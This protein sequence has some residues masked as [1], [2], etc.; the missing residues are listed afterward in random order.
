[1]P[2]AYMLG[3]SAAVVGCLW[4]V[5]DR[6]IDRV[7]LK[8]LSEWGLVDGEDERVREGLRRK[9]RKGKDKARQ[10]KEDVGGG[11][12]KKTLIEAVRDGREACVLKYLCGAA[13]VVYGVPVV[14]D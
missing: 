1:M 5:T 12:K 14:L 9:G 8:A 4:D 2:R 10:K 11:K 6:E 7:A 13:V 3:G